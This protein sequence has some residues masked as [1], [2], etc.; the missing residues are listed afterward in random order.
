MRNK[1]I[2]IVL[3]CLMMMLTLCSWV[4]TS[5]VNVY[6]GYIS[7]AGSLSGQPCEYYIDNTYNIGLENTGSIFNN[8]SSTIHGKIRVN[9]IEYDMAIY[10]GATP[11]IHY[12]NN[13][14]I[15]VD[16]R[17]DVVP[18]KFPYI[19]YVTF[20]LACILVIVL[21][22]SVVKGFNV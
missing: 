13:T 15:D 8:G 1:I 5:I 3:I 18:A 11:T 10:P 7:G 21:I 6:T 12:S 17:P 4:D 19:L 20:L 2:C 22:L 14:W 9:G 16:I